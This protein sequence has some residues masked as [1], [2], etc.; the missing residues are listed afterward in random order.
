MTDEGVE[1][2]KLAFEQKKWGEQLDVE[3]KKLRVENRKLWFSTGSI[4]IPLLVVA[5]TIYWNTLAQESANQ[6]AFEL[7]VAEVILDTR[8]VTEA[9]NRAK[10]LAA[11]F[12]TRLPADF[13]NRL[14]GLSEKL[15]RPY[16]MDKRALR[17]LLI[18]TPKERRKE[19]LDLWLM[20]NPEDKNQL[21]EG[22]VAFVE[23]R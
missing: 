20:F 21:P 22:L 1:R 10:G 19:V 4:V 8:T 6:A 11:L 9:R 18:A 14:Q 7:K 17:D 2:E 3:E 13:S 12:P 5:A 15:Q 16:V 23:N